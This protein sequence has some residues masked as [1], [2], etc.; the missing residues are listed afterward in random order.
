MADTTTT[1]NVDAPV[2]HSDLGCMLFYKDATSGKFKYLVPVRAVPATHSAPGTIEVTEMDSPIKQ[3]IADRPDVPAYEFDYN[4]TA[5]KY[6]AVKAQCGKEN[7]FLVTY[8]DKS[9]VKFKGTG[10]TWRD[11]VSPGSEVK[12]K[13]TVIVNKVDDV[14]DCSSI[15]DVTSIPTGRVHPFATTPPTE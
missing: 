10:A 1:L 2:A 14:D 3:Y 13:L 15:I 9:G 8:A 12:G 7:E 11:A 5:A 4:Y 6:G